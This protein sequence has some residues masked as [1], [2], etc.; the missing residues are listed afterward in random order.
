PL[1]SLTLVQCTFTVVYDVQNIVQRADGS[2]GGPASLQRE[3]LAALDR[4]LSRLPDRR[5]RRPGHHRPDQRCRLGAAR[6]H[7]RR[8]GHRHRPVA[9]GPP[10]PPPPPPRAP[11]PPSP[12][13]LGRWAR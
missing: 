6:R 1:P 12:W 4:R 3:G 10:P 8:R 9:G 5:A 2:H 11:P 7:G 13:C